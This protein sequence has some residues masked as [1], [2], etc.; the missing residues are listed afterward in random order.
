MFPPALALTFVL[1]AVMAHQ[2]PAAATMAAA[3][4]GGLFVFRSHAWALI[5]LAGLVVWAVLQPRIPLSVAFW[6]P[7]VLMAGAVLLPPQPLSLLIRVPRLVWPLCVVAGT[8]CLYVAIDRPALPGSLLVIPACLCAA[9]LGAG[10]ARYLALAD[11]RILTWGEHGLETITRDLLLGRITSG[12]LHDLAQPLNVI[13]MANGNLG[14]IAEHL[15]IAPDKRVQMVERI[16]RIT[17]STESAA[18]ILSLFRWF[19]RDGS[20]DQ[21]L[22]SVRSALERAVAVTRSNVRHSGVVVELRGD[23]LDH[24]LPARHGT[25]EM[26]AV[27]A[28]LCAFSGFILPDGDRTKIHGTV[29]VRADLTGAHVAITVHCTDEAGRP[30]IACTIDRATLWLVEQVARESGSTFRHVRRRGQTM[31]FSILVARDDI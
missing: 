22:L 21:G 8:A 16:R 28:L 17:T 6:T 5:G 18:A 7:A 31:R 1:L 14:Y 19:G 26:M 12:M 20:V 2:S 25:V 9:L 15:D 3:V 13:S 10:L 4:A 27:T 24:L 30:S 11:A 23:A 29:L